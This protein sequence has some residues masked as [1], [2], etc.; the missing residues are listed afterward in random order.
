MGPFHWRSRILTI[1]E[2]KRLQTFPDEWYLSGTVERQ[3]RQ[4]G[5][6]VPPLLA[7]ALARQLRTHLEGETNPLKKT[8]PEKRTLARKE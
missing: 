8:T 3:W 5:N 1:P 6:A 2:V 4:L 7:E